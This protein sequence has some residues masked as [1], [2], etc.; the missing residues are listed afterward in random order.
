MRRGKVQGKRYKGLPGFGAGLLHAGSERDKGQGTRGK[1]Q[2]E[3]SR[4]AGLYVDSGTHSRQGRPPV[5]P[6]IFP[7]VSCT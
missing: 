6:C 1:G 7:L 2:G 5:F 3:R 4:D